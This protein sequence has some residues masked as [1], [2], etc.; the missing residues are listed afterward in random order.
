MICPKCGRLADS[1]S[2]ICAAC[3]YIL[4]PSFLWEEA[5]NEDNHPAP[6]DATQE[7]PALAP[8][9]VQQRD[10]GDNDPVFID[11]AGAQASEDELMD[12]LL[13]PTMEPAAEDF[14][15]GRATDAEKATGEDQELAD[16]LLEPSLEDGVLPA[17]QESGVGKS[18]PKPSD[19]STEALNDA[20]LLGDLQEDY[21]VVETR[22]AN[23]FLTAAT[24]DV[25]R[26][27]QS[28]PLYL[29]KSVREMLRPSAVLAR[30][31]QVNAALTPFEEHIL[32]FLD[33]R[34]PLGRVAVLSELGKQD[35]EIAVSM[36]AEKRVVRLVGQTRQPSDAD[37]PMAAVP[38]E[39]PAPPEPAPE[40]AITSPETNA[41]GPSPGREHA[42]AAPPGAATLR[43]KQVARR[44]GK[45]PPK[46][47]ASSRQATETP[48]LSRTKSAQNTQI[49]TTLFEKAKVEE[50]SGNHAEAIRLLRLCIS[51]QPNVAGF[52]NRLGV[53]LAA[54]L[55][56]YPNA[57]IHLTKATEL[58]PENPTYRNNL[59]KIIAAAAAS[60]GDENA[61]AQEAPGGFWSSFRKLF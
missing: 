6:A 32:Q 61:S 40:P 18:I 4:D 47:A 24:E 20:V 58:Q 33:G 54:R 8:E 30:E 59:G 27:V 17:A 49:E 11:G 23:W 42:S 15:A 9:N 31:P 53:L 36:L 19:A 60:D 29:S 22:D 25:E 1:E 43:Q 41:P 13:E 28:V 10:S 12:W 3:D 55:K 50:E 34:R 48:S 2:V 21:D 39:N 16:W 38:P 7:I 37:E 26:P 45:R 46:P 5:E 57:I 35:L 51:D 14:A 52:H 56:D 44:L